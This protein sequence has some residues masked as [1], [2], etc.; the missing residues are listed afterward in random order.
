M[1][2]FNLLKVLDVL[3]EKVQGSGTDDIAVLL[4]GYDE[5]IRKMLRDAN[6]GL[7]RRFPID[8]AFVFEDYND[9]ELLAIFNENCK[10]SKFK[11]SS[12]K[13]SIKLL[14]DISHSSLNFL[15]KALFLQYS[16]KIFS[17]LFNFTES[18][19]YYVYCISFNF[20]FY[21]L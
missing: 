10:R 4:L 9:E 5:P 19:D 3:V 18:I 8:K 1:L 16:I 17:N 7:A 2:L 14:Q 15:N 21:F 6:Q 13:V 12:Y 11:V 20:Q